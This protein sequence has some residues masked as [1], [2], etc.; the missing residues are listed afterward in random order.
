M[1]QK[2][3]PSG[4][5]LG[6][7]T[8]H[9][10][11]WYADSSKPGQRYL[12][13]VKEDAQIRKYIKSTVTETGVSKIYIVRNVGKIEIDIHAARAG[14]VIGS[15]GKEIEKM[16]NKIAAM[17]GKQVKIMAIEIPD[18]SA[19][20]QLVAQGVAEKLVKRITF[21]RAMK[22]AISYAL[23][24]GGLGIKIQCS[25]RLGGAEMARQEFYREG[26]VPLHTLRAYVDYGFYEA[27]T[28]FGKIGVKVW[29]YKGEISEGEYNSKSALKANKK[30]ENA[31]KNRKANNETATTEASTQT[32]T[33]TP[34][35]T[36][37][38]ETQTPSTS[39]NQGGNA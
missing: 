4:Y 3:H 17:T 16:R 39:E 1:G 23:E 27:D 32:T 26:S 14:I 31:K 30:R 21:R 11:R 20:A 34:A 9:K 29:I 38:A 2:V 37:V 24:N 25:G 22:S 18:P 8:E 19:D 6:I 15:Q 10:S 33:E 35:E 7:T 13:Y 12:D 5:R 28:T 36:P